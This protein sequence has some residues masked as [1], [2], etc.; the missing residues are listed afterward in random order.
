MI[1]ELTLITVM[2]GEKNDNGYE[3]ECE[4]QNKVIAERMSVKRT[5]FYEAH[6]AGLKPTVIYRMH[7][8]DFPAGATIAV[9]HDVRYEII[10]TY[11]T[12]DAMEL[13][14]ARVT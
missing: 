3:T 9:E 6:K 7:P 11:E 5:E 1:V 10:R 12:A 4:Y 2:P 8:L 14:C 13:T